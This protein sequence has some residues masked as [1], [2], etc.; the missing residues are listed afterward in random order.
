MNFR[1]TRPSLDR[2]VS[3]LAL[4]FAGLVRAYG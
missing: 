1:L 2:S 3:A 4:I